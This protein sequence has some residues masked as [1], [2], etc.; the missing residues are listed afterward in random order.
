MKTSPSPQKFK[1]KP[2]AEKIE[3]KDNNLSNKA[4]NIY[5]TTE[6][7]EKDKRFINKEDSNYIVTFENLQP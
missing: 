5:E 7:A 1:Y 3:V 6:G 4:S 2:L